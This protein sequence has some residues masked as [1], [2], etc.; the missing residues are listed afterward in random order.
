M[1]RTLH[2]RICALSMTLK[3][4]IIVAL[5][6]FLCLRLIQIP[7]NL[8]IIYCSSYMVQAISALNTLQLVK[9]LCNTACSFCNASAIQL[10]TC[11]IY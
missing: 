10:V 2:I 7:N 6:L 9:A 3:T 1:Y 8:C 11:Y 4:T 5:T